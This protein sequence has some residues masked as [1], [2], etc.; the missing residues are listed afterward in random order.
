MTRPAL[1]VTRLHCAPPAELKDMIRALAA[2]L[3][4][5]LAREAKLR[6]TLTREANEDLRVDCGC[7]ASDDPGEVEGVCMAHW[8]LDLLASSGDPA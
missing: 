5:A 7:D 4:D 8:L 1:T 3:S 6:E 2:D